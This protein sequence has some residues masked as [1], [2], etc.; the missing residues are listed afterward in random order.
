MLLSLSATIVL[1]LTHQNTTYT[2]TTTAT[3]TDALSNQSINHHQ[4]QARPAG[5]KK[6]ERKELAQ[7]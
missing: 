5:D 1:G 4:Q 2:T 6:R 7:V 3:S